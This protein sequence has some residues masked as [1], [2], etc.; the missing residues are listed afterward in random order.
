MNRRYGWITLPALMTLLVLPHSARAADSYKID[1]VHSTVIFKARHFN[2][3]YTYGSFRKVTG[4]LVVDHKSPGKSS[5]SVVIDAASVFSADKKRDTHLRSPDF[6]NVKQYPRISFRSTKIRKTGK[7]LHVTGKLT[8][9]GKTNTITVKLTYLG[10]GKDPWG[11]KR[12]GFE[13]AFVINRGDYGI[14]KMKGAVGEKIHL[15][16]AVEGV[17]K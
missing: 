5:V 9:H 3:G 15:I 2:V 13:G 17:R 4:S 8:L 11:G 16:L 1:T 10:Q 14:T 6:L 7:L 12:V